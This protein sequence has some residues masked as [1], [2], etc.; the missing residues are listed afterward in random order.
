[1]I[2][3]VI[4]TALPIVAAI[5]LSR[6]QVVQS[7]RDYITDIA[8][9]ALMRSE[10]AADQLADASK[11]MAALAPGQAC[12]PAGL[13]RLR[14]IDLGANMLQAVG[15]MEG[16]TMRC[17]SFSDGRQYPLGPPDFRSPSG[18]EYRFDVTLLD[19]DT[20]YLAVRM[21]NTVGILQK[22]VPLTFMEDVPDLEVSTFSWSHR[23]PLIGR[24]DVPQELLSENLTGDA[25]F[26]HGDQVVAVVKSQRYDIGAMA[27]LPVG[28]GTNYAG[29]AAVLLIPLGVVV[30]LILSALLV[31]VI[32]NRLS[33]PAMIR[34][35]L[36]QR[37]FH[38]LYQ[39][40]VEFGT[41]RII[42]A[43]AL[44]RWDRG[45]AGEIP[46]DRF[47]DAA[48]EAG[49]VPLITAHVLELLADDAR[50][51]LALMADFRI[52]VNLGASDL[53]RPSILGEVDRLFSGSGMGPH[54]LVIEA[55][56]RSLVDV[57]RARD[58]IGRLRKM[59][60]RLAI[61]DFGTGYSSLAYLAQIEADI[62]KIDR[63]FV[64][65]LGTESATSQVAARIIEMGKD[66]NLRIVAEGIESKDQELLLKRLGVECGQGYL[67][68]QAMAVGDLLLR[69][70]HDGKNDDPL[71]GKPRQPRAPRVR[72][73][74]AVA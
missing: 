56:E 30:G 18:S 49:L 58:T 22:D 69:L 53:H 47:I 72:Q 42:G 46:T 19:P 50:Q 6:Q 2:G 63:L 13:A 8:S 39:P 9:R 3:V 38:L 12:A 14:A 5:N 21:G 61:D 32:R 40:V 41:G 57:D 15:W 25:V 16:E 48:E 66:L 31:Y 17:A 68:G 73:L 51:V 1:M 54:N 67:Y 37:K 29:Q 70:Y 64:Q 65:A 52:S 26:R 34:T 28:Y 59:G 20:R 74:K 45:S 43:E 11:A 71:R 36:A 23:A 24:G 33:M 44:I 62:L 7:E 10:I 60:V 35:A 27:V 4:T 55:T